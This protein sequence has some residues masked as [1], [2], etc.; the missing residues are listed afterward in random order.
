MPDAT[1][2]QNAMIETDRDEETPDHSGQTDAGQ[3]ESGQNSMIETDREEGTPDYSGQTDSGQT[4]YEHA[5]NNKIKAKFGC[6][7]DDAEGIDSEEAVEYSAGTNAD[8]E[9][10]MGYS[11][12]MNKAHTVSVSEGKDDA[13]MM[14]SECFW[15]DMDTVCVY[16]CM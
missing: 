14:D 9:V 15:N 5:G 11:A 4:E 2:G 16:V 13:S 8:N 10:A 3:T 12:G 6:N 7:R 1:S